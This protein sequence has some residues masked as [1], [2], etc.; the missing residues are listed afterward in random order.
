MVKASL[1]IPIRRASVKAAFE[2]TVSSFSLLF[3][4]TITHLDYQH[5]EEWKSFWPEQVGNDFRHTQVHKLE[6][7]KEGSELKS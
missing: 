1:I 4:M 2:V 7:H 3:S 5:M 6:R